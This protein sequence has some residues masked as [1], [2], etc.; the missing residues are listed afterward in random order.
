MMRTNIL[1]LVSLLLT[2]SCNQEIKLDEN[3]IE[4]YNDG[5]PKIVEMYQQKKGERIKKYYKEFYENGKIKIE[6]AIKNDK[7]EGIWTYFY[8][9]GN[10][11]SVGNYVDGKA[12]G[13]F[14][15]YYENGKLWAYTFYKD[16]IKEK[17]IFFD[18]NGKVLSE[19]KY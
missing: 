18:N 14:T 8:E 2:F 10:I 1:I 7:R 4:M 6:G 12:Q 11:W 15:Q 16:D 5:S 19:N 9:N 17:D 3:V 13:K